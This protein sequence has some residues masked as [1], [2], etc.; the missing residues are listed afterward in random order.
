MKK[1]S[2]GPVRFIVILKKVKKYGLCPLGQVKRNPEAKVLFP[3]EVR[4]V[5]NN[6]SKGNS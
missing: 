4:E 6:V 3:K 1:I 5:R 2:D